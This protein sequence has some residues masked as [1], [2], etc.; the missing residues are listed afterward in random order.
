MWSVTKQALIIKSSLLD[1]IECD[2]V[3]AGFSVI[4]Y[5]TLKN[6]CK[7][8]NILC[9][10]RAYSDVTLVAE[11]APRYRR[12]AL[13]GW[14]GYF[15]AARS[16]TIKYADQVEV[17]VTLLFLIKRTL[18]CLRDFLKKPF[19]L[20]SFSKDMAKLYREH[21]RSSLLPSSGS[22]YYFRTDFDFNRLVGG[23][24]GHIAGVVNHL[25]EQAG[26]APIMI[27]S[28]AIPTVKKEVECHLISPEDAF[29]DYRG[30]PTF[31]FSRTYA[32]KAA[33]VLSKKKPRFIYERFSCGS[34]SGAQLSQKFQVP[35]VLEYNGSEVWIERNWGRPF[36]YEKLFLKVEELNLKLATLIVAVSEP[37]KEQLVQRG[38]DEKK[39]LVNPNGVDPTIYSPSIDGEA[40]REKLQLADK[41]TI[42]FI[43]TFGQWH[44]AEMLAD[45]FGKLVAKYPDYRK[46]VHLMM[47]GDGVTMPQVAKLV[48]SHRIESA[49][50]L[51]GVIPQLKAPSYLAACHILV[52]PHVPNCDGSKFF[53]SPTK[54]FEYMAMGKGIVASSLDQIG[55]ILKH[56]HTAFLV[57]PGHKDSLI[58]GLKTL[59]DCPKLR[60][61]LGKNAREEVVKKYTWKCHT[62]KIIEKLKAQ[63]CSSS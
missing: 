27:T 57:K 20:R 17:K 12:A 30:L 56:D 8:G 16:F 45:C 19:L 10:F 58:R 29:L 44:G 11:F 4:D 60:K 40:V 1:S 51:T 24:I 28:T 26:T 9:K 3:G 35:F 22:P 7:S 46:K 21:K 2:Q 63:A 53:G 34:I 18:I 33:H 54:L 31:A 62:H 48:Q 38:I 52:C 6:W 32:R 14:L 13:S 37:L 49:V 42:G 25:E 39:I 47:I 50:T 15:L 59:I 41:V 43:G 55:E 5:L 23:S 61:R 36:C